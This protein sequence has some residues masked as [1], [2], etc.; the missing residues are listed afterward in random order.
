MNRIPKFLIYVIQV[1]IRDDFLICYDVALDIG[2]PSSDA[3]EA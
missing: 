1:D 2:N 3:E